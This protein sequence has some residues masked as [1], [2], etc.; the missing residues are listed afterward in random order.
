M[1]RSLH[2]ENYAL[3]QQSDITFDQGFV[4]ITG[5][6]GAGKSILLGALGL[7]IGQRTDAKVLQNPERKC[8]VEATFSLPQLDLKQLFED[9]DIDYNSDGSLILRR[10]L[11]PSGKSRAFANDT[12]VSVAFLKTLGDHIIDIHSQH[13]T[14]LVGDSNFQTSLLD[15]LADNRKLLEGY[16]K[17]YH[18]YLQLKHQLEQLTSEEEQRRKEHDYNQFLFDELQ[19]AALESDEQETLEQEA[20]LLSNA[21]D[22]KTAISQTLELTDGDES[23]ALSQLNMCKTLLSKLTDCHSEIDSLYKRLDSSLIELRDIVSSLDHLNDAISFSP[24]RQEQVNERL[25]LIYRLQK[26]HGVQTID[27]L[28]Q[29][30]DNLDQQLNLSGDIDRQIQETMEAVDEA[31]KQLQKDASALTA[32]R[33]RAARDLEKQIIPLL[34]EL[35]MSNA[36]M[37]VQ[38]TPAPDFGPQG[39][40]RISVLF[41]ANKGGQLRELSAVASGGEMSRIML[42]LKS[43]TARAA[44][45]PTIIFDEIDAGI[46]GDISVRVGRIMQQMSQS[47]QIIAITHL[48]QI[49][50]R[51]NQHFKVYKINDNSRTASN[52]ALLNSDERRHEIAVMLSAEPPTEAALKTA[53][54][55]MTL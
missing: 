54:E 23:G 46:S 33:K 35:G 53:E 45:L 6:T 55:L 51:A 48:P 32:S 3:I 17:K 44:F 19:Q 26:K 25:D 28:L 16:H 7:L 9:N 37:Q 50:A 11:L 36:Q 2:I 20:R 27:E 15:S 34:S 41:N 47:M 5:E 29:I 10:E 22:I 49:A 42:A 12:P 21:E 31:Y 40:D 38:L 4:A 8:I 43:L 1:L 52:I 39:A 18:H 30:R 13:S 14:L 24:D